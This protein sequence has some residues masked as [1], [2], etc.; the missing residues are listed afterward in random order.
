MF[1]SHWGNKAIGVNIKEK[2]LHNENSPIADL[3][4]EMG[5]ALA[6]EPSPL[7]TSKDIFII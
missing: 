1:K 3:F 7:R 6:L 4:T 2:P 5:V